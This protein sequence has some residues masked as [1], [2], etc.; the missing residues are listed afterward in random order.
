MSS[1]GASF[2]NM[3]ALNIPLLNVSPGSPH[4]PPR[5][6]NPPL[7]ETVNCKAELL[8]CMQ[9]Q[10][11]HTGAAHHLE[12]LS[13]LKEHPPPARLSSSFLTSSTA[14]FVQ[15]TS[16]I[17][18]G[19]VQITMLRHHPHFLA[20]SKHHYPLLFKHCVPQTVFRAFI[21]ALLKN[22]TEI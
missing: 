6:M 5:G 17:C 1:F 19:D 8:P 16:F 10:M 13:L 11:H 21:Q 14:I 2:G 9:S 20:G 18:L 15:I 3:E 7:L 22:K 4:S 12:M